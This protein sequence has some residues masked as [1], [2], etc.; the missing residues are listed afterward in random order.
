LY[1]PHI[2]NI[3][4][5]HITS[6]APNQLWSSSY[7]GTVRRTDIESQAFIEAFRAPGD[8][9]EVSFH[10]AAF[11][12][13]SDSVYLAC[14]TGEVVMLDTRSGVANCTAKAHDGE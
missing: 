13:T 6:R 11:G 2:G 10:D 8:Y 14:N 4:S 1:R 3:S 12:I 5:L 9:N 7:D